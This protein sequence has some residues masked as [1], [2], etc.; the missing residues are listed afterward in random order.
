[1]SIP[2]TLGKDEAVR[3][4]KAGMAGALSAS[5]ILKL[6]EQTWSGDSMHFRASALGQ[7]ATGTVDVG[8]DQVRLDVTLPWLLQRFAEKVQAVFAQRTR[9]LLERK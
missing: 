2:H 3:R 1:V 4:L 5:P 8:D 7:V 9:L 6:D